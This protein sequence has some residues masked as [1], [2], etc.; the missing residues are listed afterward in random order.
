MAKEAGALYTT[1]QGGMRPAN[2]QRR[3]NRLNA[4]RSLCQLDLEDPGL[5]STRAMHLIEA[6]AQ[7]SATQRSRGG[8]WA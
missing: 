3:Q 6:S 8:S 5:L 7:M 2:R 1:P 4:W